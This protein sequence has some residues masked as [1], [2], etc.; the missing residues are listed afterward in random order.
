MSVLASVITIVVCLALCVF[1]YLKDKKEKEPVPLLV[2]LLVGGAAV[3]FPA[4]YLSRALTAFIDSVFFSRYTVIIGANLLTGERTWTFPWAEI[5]HRF[6]L[7]FIAVALVSEI[8]KWLM[9]FFVTFK[10]DNFNCRF[11]GVVYSVVVT[12]GY[13]IAEN[14]RFACANGWETFLRHF[15]FTLPVH[16]LCGILMGMIYSRYHVKSLANKAEN[17]MIEHGALKK[18]KLKPPVGLLILSFIVPAL[19]RTV[20]EYI[21][22]LRGNRYDYVIYI[23]SG[24]VLVLCF[25]AVAVLSKNDNSDVDDAEKIIENAHWDYESEDNPVELYDSREDNGEVDDEK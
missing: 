7:A 6:L 22:S 24:A 12:M 8:H 17:K 4:Y 25:V 16:L 9:L 15:I 1:I 23:V 10:N 13:A 5:A 19:L 3:Y 18:N 21:S 2:I 20:S 11:D 14:I